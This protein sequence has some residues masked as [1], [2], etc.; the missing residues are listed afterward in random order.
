[1][2]NAWQDLLNNWPLEWTWEDPHGRE[3]IQVHRVWQVPLNIN[4]LKNPSTQ[5]IS[6]TGLF[7]IELSGNTWDYIVEKPF[8][9]TKSDKW[10]S[11]SSSLKEHERTHTEEKPF[12]CTKVWQAAQVTWKPMRWSTQE[13][14]HSL[15]NIKLFGDT[16]YRSVEKNYTK[17]DKCF[18]RSSSLKE[19]GGTHTG[20]MPFR[21]SK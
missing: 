16:K 1:M 2:T 3:A 7:N 11:R 5:E 20:E 8:K 18:S 14:S 6:H 4:L 17:C 9:C 21:C 13:K 15:L 10:F 12:N 19:H